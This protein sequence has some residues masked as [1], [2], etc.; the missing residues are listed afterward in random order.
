MSERI[1]THE[2]IA[3]TQEALAASSPAAASATGAAGWSGRRFFDGLKDLGQLRIISQ[4][5]PSTFE[6]IVTFG[7]YGVSDGHVNAITPAYHWH[8]DLTRFAHVRSRDE[9]Y[10]RSGRRVLFFELREEADAEPFLRIFLYRDK[11]AEFEPARVAAFSAMHAELA[12][13]VVLAREGVDR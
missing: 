1:T 2:A 9:I 6:S 5:G 11:G 7:T 10:P 13:G 4:C 3:P 8:L 12:E